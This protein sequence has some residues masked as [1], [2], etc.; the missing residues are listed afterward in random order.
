MGTRFNRE[1]ILCMTNEAPEQSWRVD[2][3]DLSDQLDEADPV[4]RQR[5]RAVVGELYYRQFYI[6]WGLTFAFYLLV[7]VR[8]ILSVQ[9]DISVWLYLSDGTV[10][11]LLMLTFVAERFGKLG[12]ESI[13]LAPIPIA[14]AMVV[15]VYLHVVLAGDTNSMMRGLLIIMAFSVVSMLPWI[16]WVLTGFATLAHTLI[17]Y[18]VLGPDSTQMI[19]VGV[20][21]L[22]VSYGGFVVRYNSIREQARL[23]LINQARAEKMEQ[24]AEAK[25]EFI[26]NMSH[27]LRTP[28]TGLLGMVNLLDKADLGSEE[29]YYLNTAKTSAETLGIVIDDILSLS[30]LGAGKLQLKHEAFDLNLLLSE[31]SEMM[32]VG[33]KEKGIGLALKLPENPV[34]FLMGDHDR[35]RQILFNLLGNAVKFTDHGQV[36]LSAFVLHQSK[37]RVTVRLKVEDTGVGIAEQDIDRLFLRFEQ[38]DSSS[39]RARSGTGLGLAIC[40]EL[41]DLMGFEIQVQSTPGEGSAFWFD[42]ATTI[43]NSDEVKPVATGNMPEAEKTIH[44]I[45]E[46]PLRVLVVEDNPVNQMLLRKLTTVG[47]WKPEFAADGQEAVILAERR[48]FDVILMDI[49]MPVMNGEDATEA[50]RAG[51]GPNRR[52]P[53]IALTANCLPEDVARYHEKGMAE[54]IAKPVKFEQ[55]YQTIDRIVTEMAG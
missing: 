9:T 25:D 38:V 26:A 32:S 51:A 34:P 4:V 31:V 39:T 16:F 14:M 50:I 49:Q 7:T 36:V 42:F 5:I 23:N 24:L 27:E 44:D 30:R 3:S 45:K 10:L 22:M 13:H 54:T 47:R 8:D 1:K 52:T 12:V 41:A 53:I 11:G 28:L 19:A 2:Y 21:A 33:A 55:F 6:L 43:A 48:P 37:N 40:R 46:K 18:H 15:N 29:R 35:L 17:A 20:G